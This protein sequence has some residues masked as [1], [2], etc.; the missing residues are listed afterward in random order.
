MHEAKER[1]LSSLALLILSPHGGEC[2][3]PFFLVF[4][5]LGKMEVCIWYHPNIP[6]K[7]KYFLER[8]PLIGR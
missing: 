8:G 1:E 5:V 7:R 2:A 4:Y 6:G 3:L